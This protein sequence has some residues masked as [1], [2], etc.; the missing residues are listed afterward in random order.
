[1]ACDA[2]AAVCYHACGC[3]ACHKPAGDAP[4]AQVMILTLDKEKGRV[5]LSTKKLEPTPGD[6]LRDPGL[7]YRR[8]DEMAAAFRR[9]GRARSNTLMPLTRRRCIRW[10]G[11][12]RREEVQARQH[13][14]AR[15][16]ASLTLS[17]HFCG[18]H[19]FVNLCP[20]GCRSDAWSVV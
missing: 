1:M 4:R 8:A 13:V 3:P 16:D 19:C 15:S 2:S 5:S 20:A 12:A 10:P 9:A 6:M 18:L 17:Q 14:A 11:G 7:V